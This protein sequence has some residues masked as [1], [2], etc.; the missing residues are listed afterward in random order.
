MTLHLLRYDFSIVMKQKTLV[1]YNRQGFLFRSE[2]LVQSLKNL[3]HD[4]RLPA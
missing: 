1:C 4:F 2:S 3:R